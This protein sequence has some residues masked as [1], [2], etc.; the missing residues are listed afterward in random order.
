MARAV[1][2]ASLAKLEKWLKEQ[3]TD[4]HIQHQVM[5]YLNS[6]GQPTNI[7]A[8]Q[9]TTAKQLELSPDWLMDGWPLQAWRIQQETTWNSI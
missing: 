2:S 1:W 4:N 3:C 9:H 6:W 5:Q 8:T 7:Y